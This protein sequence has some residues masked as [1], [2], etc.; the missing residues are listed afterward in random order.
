[1]PETTASRVALLRPPFPS[2]I[3]TNAP[4]VP[5]PLICS[6]RCCPFGPHWERFRIDIAV[7]SGDTPIHRS[8]AAPRWCLPAKFKIAGGKTARE[9]HQCQGF[10]PGLLNSWCAAILLSPDW[11]PNRFLRTRRRPNS[12]VHFPWI[13]SLLC[14]RE[15]SAT[16]LLLI[17]ILR[18]TCRSSKLPSKLASPPVQQH[19]PSL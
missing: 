2:L 13:A 12:E 14:W 1:M 19:L 4:A 11:P 10:W 15:I 7:L 6:G 17:L 3:A 9:P 16:H 8:A 18:L 5:A